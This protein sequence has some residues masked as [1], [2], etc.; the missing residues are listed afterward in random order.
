MAKT[1]LTLR[2][3]V[4]KILRRGMLLVFPIANAREPASLW[5]EFFP[6]KKMRWE[7][8]EGGDASVSDLWF[9]RGKLSNCGKVVYTKWFRGRATVIAPDL[10]SALIYLFNF[11]AR[12]FKPLGAEARHILESLEDNSP[13]SPRHLKA[14][15]DLR[16]KDSEAIYNRAL[17]QLWDRALIVG[18]GEIDDGAFPSL[19]LGS[20][21]LL[22]EPL[23]QAAA[24]M[25]EQEAQAI[26]EKKLPPNSPFRQYLDRTLKAYSAV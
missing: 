16:G 15:T 19:A 23:W 6:R 7:W 10:F 9:L 24:A 13:Q 12:K 18:F 26:I 4:P 22:F 2:A 8:D 1:H 3:A 20:S 14:L 17:K 11:P 25:T 5:C 21:R